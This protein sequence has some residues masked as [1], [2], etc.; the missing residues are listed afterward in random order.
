MGKT[1]FLATQIWL[2]GNGIDILRMPQDTNKKNLLLDKFPT[3]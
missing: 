2:Q 1:L 3:S